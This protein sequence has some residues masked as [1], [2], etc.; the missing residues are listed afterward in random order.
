M[1]TNQNVSIIYTLAYQYQLKELQIYIVI[2]TRNSILQMCSRI[3][4]TNKIL[5]IAYKIQ[6]IAS[7]HIMILWLQPKMLFVQFEI[8]S[9]LL[10][11]VFCRCKETRIIQMVIVWFIAHSIYVNWKIFKIKTIVISQPIS[12][13]DSGVWYQ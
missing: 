12:L 6:F 4:M 13:V 8:F 3:K 5:R 11:D 10:I 9:M 1:M 2:N 7:Q